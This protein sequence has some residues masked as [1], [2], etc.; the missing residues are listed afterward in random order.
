MLVGLIGGLSK[1]C[2]G[3]ISR[4]AFFVGSSSFSQALLRVHALRRAWGLGLLRPREERFAGLNLG[5]HM[6]PRLAHLGRCGVANYCSDA[7]VI[8]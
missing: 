7:S 2:S 8:D 1:V 3:S 6:G 4:A 5:L